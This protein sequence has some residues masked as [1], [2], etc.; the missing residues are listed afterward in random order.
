VES[1]KNEL[2]YNI[3]TTLA[4]L[5]DEVRYAVEEGIGNCADWTAV[6][7]Y[8]KLLRIVA[9]ASGR[10]FVGKPLCR[11][12][13]W[14]KWTINYTVDCS[15]AIQDV[16]SIRPWLRPFLARFQPSIRTAM[17]YRHKVAE[18][19]KPQVEAMIEASKQIEKEG[20]DD[21]FEVT[22]SDQYSLATWSMVSAPCGCLFKRESTSSEN[23]TSP[24]LQQEI[25][26]LTT[27]DIMARTK[28]QL[29]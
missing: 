18:K 15:Q 19:L 6:K 10:I 25:L 17:G 13:D 21:H 4:I 24:Q 3:N 1:V 8:E 22:P 27:R 11:D 28:R 14:I 7:V 26:T 5:Q 23:S 20:E 29:P 16:G 2:T 12:E 9:L